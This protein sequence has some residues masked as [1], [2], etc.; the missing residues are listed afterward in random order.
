[1]TADDPTKNYTRLV[2]ILSIVV[3]VSILGF[4]IMLYI[5]FHNSKLAWTNYSDNEV[6]LRLALSRLDRNLGY[7][8]LIHNFKDLVARRDLKQYQDRI[9]RDI[10]NIRAGISEL[11]QLLGTEPE[12]RALAVIQSTFDEYIRKYSI[13]KRLIAK[14]SG[15]TRIDKAIK[16]QDEDA[17]KALHFLSTT[18]D[19]RLVNA[20]GKHSK[21]MHQLYLIGV[22]GSIYLFVL[23]LIASGVIITLVGKLTSTNVYLKNNHEKAQSANSSLTKFLGSMSHEM[24]TPL[25]AVVGFAQLLDMKLRDGELKTHAQEIISAGDYLIHLVN[26]LLDLTAIETGNIKLQFDDH[27]MVVIL[28]ECVEIIRPL[29][30]K[31][32]VDIENK[33]TQET[34]IPVRVDVRRIQQVLLNV[35]SNA[36]KFNRENGRITIDIE[37][38]GN[39]LRLVISDTGIG[40]TE[41]QIENIFTPFDRL[42]AEKSQVEGAGLGMAISKELMEKMGGEIGLV[43]EPGV[44]T[45]VWVSLPRTHGP[46]K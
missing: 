12:R 16:I 21:A 2:Y 32:S 9:D 26:E 24:R 25:T 37:L 38:T 30:D 36:V 8:G 27:D 7:G 34:E 23:L 29:A 20:A 46:G 22:G 19:D 3:T 39:Y 10:R 31:R 17:V 11:H 43:S 15:P 1:L 44:G 45:R 42:G 33:V 14:G 13:A 6:R 4:S 35:L 40:L 41:T 5:G 28:R 18:V